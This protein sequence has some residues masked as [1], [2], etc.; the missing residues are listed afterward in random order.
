MMTTNNQQVAIFLKK[1]YPTIFSVAVI[2]I[3][4]SIIRGLVG[5]SEAKLAEKKTR[6]ELVLRRELANPFRAI[7]LEAKSVYVLDLTT[8]QEIFNKNSEAQLPLASLTKTMTAIV[9]LEAVPDFTNVRI[10]NSSL[11]EEGDSGFRVGEL[12]PLRELLGFSLTA[13]S[14]DGVRAIAEVLGEQAQHQDQT[15]NPTDREK[16]VELMN[17]KSQNMGLSQTFFL[18][19]T[20]LDISS[21]TSGSYGSAKDVARL[22]GYALLKHGEV[23][24]DTG[25]SDFSAKIDGKIHTAV[26]TNKVVSEIPGLIASKTGFTDLAGGNLVIA[27]DAGLMRPIIISVLG[28]SEEGRFK[29]AL[30]LVSSSIEYLARASQ[31]EISNDK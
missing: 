3:I 9:A 22:F 13:S 4:F 16:F 1:H 27:F 19:E 12:W 31:G 26:N 23:F 2:L 24:E 14:N 5:F 7:E 11:R 29:D 18:N 10:S 30:I 20:G 15:A 8:G 25:Y 28:S 6:D 17:L 21:S